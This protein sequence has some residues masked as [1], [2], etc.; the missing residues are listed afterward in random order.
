MSK[1][2]LIGEA[3][4][5]IGLGGI[6]TPLLSVLAKVRPPRVTLWDDDTVESHNLI[7]QQ[8]SGADVG[9][10]KVVAAASWLQQV[11]VPTEAVQQRYREPLPFDGIVISAVDS[12]ESR[13]AIWQGVKHPESA[14]TL[15]LDG[16]LSRES[17]LFAQLFVIPISDPERCELYEEWFAIDGGADSGRRDLD[18]I[19]APIV[20]S[21]LIA[22]ILVRWSRKDRLPWQVIWDGMSMSLVPMD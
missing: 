2:S 19:P 18:M 9:V 14:V 11:G 1:N 17:P 16:R 22:T 8:W 7:T 3:I 12:I 15:F 20:L 4:T 6:G 10:A 13:R 5:L 21:G